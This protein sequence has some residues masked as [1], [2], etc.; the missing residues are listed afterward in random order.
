MRLSPIVLALGLAASSL[1][2]AGC[3]AAPDDQIA[4]RSVALLKQGEAA[5]AAGQADRG[6]RRARNRA[7]RRSAQPRRLRRHGRVAIKQQ[8][9]G[10]AIRL[11][12]KALA[13]EPNRSRRAGA[14]R[15][16]RWSSAARSRGRK[17]NLAQAAEAVRQR[18]PQAAKLA[19]GHRR[20]P[21]AVAAAKPPAGA[22]RPTK[23]SAR[24]QRRR[25]RRRASVSARRSEIDA[26]VGPAPPA[27]RAC[28]SGSG[29]A[30][31]GAGRMRRRSAVRASPG[32]TPSGAVAGHDVDDRRHRPWA[33]GRRPS[34]APSSPSAGRR[35]TGPRP[36]AGHNARCRA[37]RRSARRPRA[38]TSG[39]ATPP[40]RP[41]SPPSQR[42][43]SAVP[44]L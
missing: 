13:L 15:A 21:D 42:S 4:P 7:G 31:C 33:A 30:S 8:L 6:R 43:S 17:E 27:R 2:V 1:A 39:S 40:R 41:G 25:I 20:G 19:R 36:T 24:A 9:F 26:Q 10:Q 38:G 44:T 14:C 37:P 34:G 28:P 23:L 16:R 35:A 11:T 22:Q 29:G 18:C 12:N 5:L 3:R 32:S